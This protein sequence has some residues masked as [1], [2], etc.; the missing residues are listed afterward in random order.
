METLYKPEKVFHAL[1]PVPA[2]VEAFFSKLRLIRDTHGGLTPLDL[3]R[4]IKHI[5]GRFQRGETRLARNRL[6]ETTL[7]VCAWALANQYRVLGKRAAEWVPLG[8][9]E[10]Q[11]DVTTIRGA[12]NLLRACMLQSALVWDDYNRAGARIAQATI[13]Q[14]RGRHCLTLRIVGQKAVLRCGGFRVST[15]LVRGW[16]L[17]TMGNFCTLCPP[18]PLSLQQ[19]E[20]KFPVD[21]LV[22]RP[23][24]LLCASAAGGGKNR[25][26][27]WSSTCTMEEVEVPYRWDAFGQ[28]EAAMVREGNVFRMEITYKETRPARRGY[29]KR[30]YRLT[31]RHRVFIGTDIVVA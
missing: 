20:P 21:D 4:V 27:Q 14:R 1:Q 5:T 15:G 3:D 17:L 29:G 2:D 24:A 26:T 12:F 13:L 31:R 30:T 6:W 8:T 23:A 28:H 9:L 16:G 18:T 22:V 25:L 7:S 10:E 19:S 11:N